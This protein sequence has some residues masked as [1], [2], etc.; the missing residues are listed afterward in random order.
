MAKE[1]AQDQKER[2]QPPRVHINYKVY[3]EGA[4][5]IRELPFVVGVLA[6]LSGDAAQ[7]LPRLSERKFDE[8]NRYNFDDFLKGS[9]PRIKFDVDNRLDKRGNTTIPVDL[10]IESIKDFEPD[11]LVQKI[12]PLREL[13]E[14]R[15]KLRSLLAQLSNSDELGDQ[16]QKILQNKQDLE[17]LAQEVGWKPESTEAAPEPTSEGDQP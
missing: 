16:L 10:T 17:R 9:K 7:D 3:N 4:T 1:S 5:E 14:A 2:N 15:K 6:D 8:V 12:K 13:L 11:Q